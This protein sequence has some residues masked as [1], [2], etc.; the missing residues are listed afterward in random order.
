M[1]QGRVLYVHPS[2]LPVDKACDWSAGASPYLLA[3][4]GIIG[5]ANALRGRGLDVVGINYPM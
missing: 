1:G 4:M 2:K 5:L 3:P